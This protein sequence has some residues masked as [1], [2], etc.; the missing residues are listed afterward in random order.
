VRFVIKPSD[1]VTDRLRSNET[2][3]A[4]DRIISSKDK[5]LITPNIYREPYSTSDGN[6]SRVGDALA[7]S[8]HNKCAY[9]ERILKIDIE[10]YRPKKKVSE[11]SN[12]DGYYWLCYEWT[13]LLPSC[14]TCNREGAKH[15]KFP[16]L[17]QRVN[18]PNFDQNGLVVENTLSA[19]EPPLLLEIPG[20]LHPEIDVPDAYFK[21]VLHHT[22]GIAMSPLHPTGN[23]EER[24][25]L[26]IEI[27][28]LNR[29][30]LRLNRLSIINELVNSLEMAMSKYVNDQEVLSDR[31][32]DIFDT[33]HANSL[34]PKINHSL[35][36]KFSIQ[37]ENNFTSVVLP[38]CKIPVV[39][40]ILRAAFMRWMADK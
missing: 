29:E 10:H 33:F 6:Q 16:V 25:R 28:K 37:S 31:I 27:C 14:I 24:A 17:G 2:K 36:R 20:L 11:D 13:N 21:F 23:N 12:H 35:L 18:S 1:D 15:N 8:Y 3:I 7:N 32:M 5:K 38:S 34:N 9:C 22:S 39:R 26:T 19:Y 40:N 4:L 30:A